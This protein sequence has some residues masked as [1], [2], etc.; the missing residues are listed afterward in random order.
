VVRIAGPLEITFYGDLPS[1][2]VGRATELYLVVGTP[3]IGPG[4][5]AMVGYQDTIPEGIPVLAEVTLPAAKAGSQPVK[6]KFELKER[7]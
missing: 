5:L 4:T 7:C 2:R 3:G 6:L 1:L